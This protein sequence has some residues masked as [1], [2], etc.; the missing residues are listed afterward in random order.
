MF[1]SLLAPFKVMWKFRAMP[2]TAGNQILFYKLSPD[3]QTGNQAG[4]INTVIVTWS[5]LYV[6][7]VKKA[8]GRDSFY[9]APY[10][11]KLPLVILDCNISCSDGSGSKFFDPGRVNFLWL[12]QVGSG[13][14]FMV[15]VRIWKI[16]PKNIK[17]FNFYC[18]G[19]GRPLIYCGSKVSSGRVRAH[20]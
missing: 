3:Q 11:K 19:L 12:Y 4:S 16:S 5:V 1:F 18:F 13:Q 8:L 6:V 7:Q 17:F 20:L 15:W 14:P 10:S 9:P 2:A